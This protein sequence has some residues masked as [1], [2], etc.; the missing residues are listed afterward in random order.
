VERPGFWIDCLGREHEF[1]RYER[2]HTVKVNHE[3]Q[4]YLLHLHHRSSLIIK[5]TARS[6]RLLFLIAEEQGD[7]ERAESAPVLI[8]ANHLSENVFAVTVWH[9]LFSEAFN[10]MGLG[11]TRPSGGING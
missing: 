4:E 10:Q 7:D 9:E 1:W 6:G 8:V 5:A 11:E 2:D 3:G